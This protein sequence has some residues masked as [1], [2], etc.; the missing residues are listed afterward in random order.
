VIYKFWEGC[1]LILNTLHVY[2]SPCCIVKVFVKNL[3]FMYMLIFEM[4][5]ENYGNRNDAITSTICQYS[6]WQYLFLD[7]FSVFYI[8][9]AAVCACI[10]AVLLQILAFHGSGSYISYFVG[11]CGMCGCW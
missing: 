3:Q 2:S 7:S 8:A 4:L 5:H 9:I 10:F 11:P 6:A 1:P